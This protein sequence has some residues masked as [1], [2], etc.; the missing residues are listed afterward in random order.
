MGQLNQKWA[1]IN[2]WVDDVQVEFQG[3]DEELF[4]LKWIHCRVRAHFLGMASFG[5][6]QRFESVTTVI[7]LL[8]HV[9]VGAP[10]WHPAI[11]KNEHEA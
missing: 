11:R 10:R 1:D 9:P 8:R 6:I 2:L 3:W 4:K 5:L 7:S